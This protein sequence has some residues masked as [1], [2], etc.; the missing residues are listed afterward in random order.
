MMQLRMARWLKVLALSLFVAGLGVVSSGPAVTAAALNWHIGHL[1]DNDIYSVAC[2]TATECLG[3]GSYGDNP[4]EAVILATTSGGAKWVNQT[5]PA[6][7]TKAFFRSLVGMSCPTSTVCFSIGS[8]SSAGVIVLSTRNT[9]SLWTDQSLPASLTKTQ[10]IY[11]SGVTCPTSSQCFGYGS[12]GSEAFL[13]STANAGTKWIRQS[14]PS[15]IQSI[16]SLHCVATG[17]PNSTAC[18]ATGS[19][20]SGDP[21]VL[22]TASAGASWTIGTLPSGINALSGVTCPSVSKCFAIGDTAVAQYEFKPLILA[23]NDG[24]LKWKSQTIPSYPAGGDVP[25]AS[26]S[27]PTTSTCFVAGVVTSSETSSAYIL[28]TANGGTNWISQNLP[29]TSSS[30]EASALDAVSCPTTKICYTTGNI[31][32]SQGGFSSTLVLST[33]T[34]GN[35]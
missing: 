21:V 15:G 17:S 22:S 35:G 31:Y 8:T 5:L 7:V 11:P 30:S 3:V 12:L 14:F 10:S 1:T 20:T 25:L 4:P 19:A 34:G 29:A 18:V 24:G 2:P 32:Q 27:C 26:I 33:T 23:S 6:N 13:I 9:G 16:S 28:S